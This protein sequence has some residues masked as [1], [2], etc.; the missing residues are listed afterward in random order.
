M[1]PSEIE[2]AR[3]EAV[4]AIGEI[5]RKYGMSAFMTEGI[6]L[7]I[8]AGIREEELYEMTIEKEE[9]IR[10]MSEE[11]DKA[12]KAAKKVLSEEER[13]ISEEDAK[14][15]SGRTERGRDGG[16]TQ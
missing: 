11:L 2:K 9:W 13:E 14:D 12:K 8:L 1:L 7:H 16:I 4:E 6:M 5:K 10:Q 15:G 3:R